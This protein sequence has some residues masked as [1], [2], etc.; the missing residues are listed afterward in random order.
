M[1]GAATKAE[2]ERIQEDELKK[3]TTARRSLDPLPP[4]VATPPS[5][6]L[7]PGLEERV[8]SRS[9][10][11]ALGEERLEV[12]STDSDTETDIE[13]AS[14]D[15]GRINTTDSAAIG[16]INSTDGAIRISPVNTIVHTP[17]SQQAEK[18]TPF[19]FTSA[20]AS[21]SP[22]I[23]RQSKVGGLAAVAPA[24]LE[25]S[26]A[27]LRANIE[28]K[29]EQAQTPEVSRRARVL[30]GLR[31]FDV[32][33]DDTSD[34][35]TSA[36]LRRAD[37]FTGEFGGD[38]MV[39]LRQQ[40]VQ[41]ALENIELER[42]VSEL[43]AQLGLEAQLHTDRGACSQVEHAKERP[44]PSRESNGMLWGRHVEHM[45]SREGQFTQG[46][47]VSLAAIFSLPR[48]LSNVSFVFSVLRQQLP[49]LGS[50]LL[51]RPSRRRLRWKSRWRVGGS[52]CG[53]A[54]W[55]CVTGRWT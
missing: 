15:L 45:S 41:A 53:L 43:R 25:L 23:R 30:E 36:T 8:G 10:D 38:A 31:R 29:I 46:A 7:A 55:K 1:G 52:M 5:S 26:E 20:P 18:H 4:N 28:S 54:R 22:K 44:R 24:P 6:P 51:D 39:W 14:L 17:E 49:R 40:R 2:F 9:S 35:N 19:I 50:F 12:A 21:R 47:K 16:Q 27:P 11:E 37:S 33:G 48:Y 42:E 34:V 3:L 32:W 13:V